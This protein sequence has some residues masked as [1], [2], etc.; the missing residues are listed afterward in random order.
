MKRILL[1]LLVAICVVLQVSLLPALRPLGVVPDLVLV[2]VVLIGMEGTASTALAAA[3]AAGLA[4]DLVSGA[5]FGLWTGLLVL[6]ALTTGLIHRA[7]IELAGPTVAVVIVTAGTLLSTLVVLL[8][9]VSSVSAWPV[10][11]LLARLACELLLNLGLTIAL[12]P[13]VQ[14]MVPGSAEG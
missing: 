2:L 12:R 8:G 10:G 9:L 5:N 6:A 4:L 13:L 3:V 11:S 7:G 1:A 14:R